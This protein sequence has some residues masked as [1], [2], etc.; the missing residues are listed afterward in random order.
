MP[1]YSAALYTAVSHCHHIIH[2]LS[3]LSY[4]GNAFCHLQGGTGPLLPLYAVPRPMARHRLCHL[5]CFFCT[6]SSAD[7]PLQF[8]ICTPS[9]LLI[10]RT[11]SPA[12][13]P[14]AGAVHRRQGSCR[15]FP[16]GCRG[17]TIRCGLFSD[18]PTLCKIAGE[19]Q[20]SCGDWAGFIV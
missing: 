10:H 13:G 2:Q 9:P 1:S 15:V 3:S 8:F 11:C 19:C 18:V 20:H 4:F 5:R 7:L 17:I 6:L 12:N 14:I 16:P